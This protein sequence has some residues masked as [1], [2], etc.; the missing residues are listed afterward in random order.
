LVDWVGL[1]GQADKRIKHLSLG[2]K[3]RLKLAMALVSDPEFLVLDEPFNGLDP[4]GIVWLRELLQ[5]HAMRGG[6]T[7]V[8]SH[9]I[10]ELQDI[11]GHVVIIRE[12][13]IVLEGNPD[14]FIEAERTTVEFADANRACAV[15]DAVGVPWTCSGS[16][17]LVDAPAPV[18][19]ELIAEYSL[20]ILEMRSSSGRGLERVYMEHASE[21]S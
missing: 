16:L 18:V 19:G 1:D 6:T 5:D 3:Q 17:F 9:L 21:K 14:D 10:A 4:E 13:K 7:L 8:S 15:L 11:I 12:G 20:V 2:Q